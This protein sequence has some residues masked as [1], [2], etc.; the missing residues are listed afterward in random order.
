MS[1]PSI[2]VSI[3]RKVEKINDEGVSVAAVEKPRQKYRQGKS[4]PKGP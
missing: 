3:R 4:M 1:A 2:S